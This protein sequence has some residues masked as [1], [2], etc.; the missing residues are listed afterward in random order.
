[1]SRLPI[2][3]VSVSVALYSIAA[4]RLNQLSCRRCQTALDV[5][6][7]DTNQPEKFLGTCSSCGCWYRV[8]AR[9]SEARATVMQ[10]PEVS[11]VLKP[12]PQPTGAS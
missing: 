6:Q 11:E 4:L 8:E 9:L 7:P 5:H 2:R 3:S 10:L 12:G 1:M